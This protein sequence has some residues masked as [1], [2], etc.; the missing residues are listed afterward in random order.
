MSDSTPIR[1]GKL[2]AARKQ[3]QTSIKLWFEDGDPVST[4]ALAFA[5]YEVIHAIS[6]K[7]DPNRR[8]LLF[9]SDLIKDEYRGLYCQ[10]LKSHAYFFKHADRDGDSVIDFYPV[11]S[12]LFILFAVLGLELC[13]ERK[14]SEE[15]ALMWWLYIN[16]PDLLTEKGRKMVTDNLKVEDI[17]WLR[18]RPKSEFLHAF[19]EARRLTESGRQ[20]AP[21]G[22]GYPLVIPD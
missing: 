18:T 4:H 14:G 6:K 2:D 19:R 13:G 7:R 10:K 22:R 8:D 3:L 15:S 9:D 16:R 11:L 17:K 1:I 5:A 21:S 12:D 20:L